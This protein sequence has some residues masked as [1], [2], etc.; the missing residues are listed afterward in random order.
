MSRRDCDVYVSVLHLPRR[1]KE[2]T[3]TGYLKESMGRSTDT[4]ER[5]E[6]IDINSVN[7]SRYHCFVYSSEGGRRGGDG[8]KHEKLGRIF[9]LN[10]F[11][12]SRYDI[13]IYIRDEDLGNAVVQ[14]ENERR[15]EA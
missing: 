5:N 2:K 8:T 7:L 13:Y 12:V 11:R 15:R 1:K 3:T 14:P 4:R 10:L 9:F 6:S